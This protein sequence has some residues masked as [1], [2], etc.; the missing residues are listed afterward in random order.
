M[1]VILVG[2]LISLLALNANAGNMYVYKDK[3]GQVILNNINPS[4]DFDKFSE[5][6][7]V[8]YYEDTDEGKQE[9]AYQAQLAKKPAAAIGMTKEQVRNKT[10]WGE[11]NDINTT[12]NKYGTHE[13]WVYDDYQYLY[14]DNGKLTTIQQ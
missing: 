4:G 10:N 9:A 8:T 11:P 1:K 12:T 6:V 5:K 3:G 2:I 14:F 7:K 13:Q